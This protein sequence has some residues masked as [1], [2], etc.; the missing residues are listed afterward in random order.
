MNADGLRDPQCLQP[1]THQMNN[2]SE[3]S[4]ATNPA[5][6]P[7]DTG[8][9]I[10]WFQLHVR[11]FLESVQPEKRSPLDG[12]ARNLESIARTVNQELSVCF[13]GNAGVGKST[14]I[15]SLVAGKD[16]ILPAG[17]IGPLTAQALAVRYAPQRRFEVEYHAPRA[18][19]HLAFALEGV[20][21]RDARRDR[22]PAG[23]ADDL[24]QR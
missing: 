5:D 18:L 20:L 13:L 8:K 17:G 15:N 1:Y 12:D 7:A 2:A 21:T 24:G 14:L 16:V 11:P 4:S 10:R 23:V 3:N 22:P 19:W 9:L 6:Q